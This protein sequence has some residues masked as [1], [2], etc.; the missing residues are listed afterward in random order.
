MNEFTQLHIVDFIAVFS[1]GK[2]I[3]IVLDH[4]FD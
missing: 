4:Q 2:V 3:Y 1:S